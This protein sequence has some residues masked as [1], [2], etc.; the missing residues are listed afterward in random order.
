MAFW[1]FLILGLTAGIAVVLFCSPLVM[2]VNTSGGVIEVRWTAL[3]RG[4]WPLRKEG[5]GA[6]LYVAGIPIPL[7]PLARKHRKKEVPEKKARS[8]VSPVSRLL[9]FLRFCAADAR[10]RKAIVV[11]GGKLARGTVQ[12]FELSRWHAELSFADPAANGMLAGWLA[13]TRGAVRLPVGVNFLGR[14]WLELEVRLYPYR[15]VLAGSAFLLRLPH[16]AILRHWVASK[17]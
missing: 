1:F 11:P 9:R 17:T 4:L 6:R 2:T 3:L 14:N 12:S 13:A 8:A 7:P 16:R 10:L 5:G 15:L